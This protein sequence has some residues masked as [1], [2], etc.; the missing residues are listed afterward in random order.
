MMNQLQQRDPVADASAS[1]LVPG[2]GQWLQ[3][4]R[5]AAVLFAG[6]VAAAAVVG[7]VAP[8]FRTVALVAALAVGAWSAADAAIAARRPRAGV[9][10]ASRGRVR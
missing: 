9:V 3:Q 1:L 7:V 6:E 5:A 4:R 10:P 8:E 2:L